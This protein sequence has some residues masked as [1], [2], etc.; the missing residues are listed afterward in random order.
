VHQAKSGSRATEVQQGLLVFQDQMV[1][2]VLLVSL[3]SLV[4]S[5]REEP[6]ALLDRKVTVGLPDSRVCRAIL[7]SHSAYFPLICIQ[8]WRLFLDVQQTHQHFNSGIRNVV[9]I[10]NDCAQLLHVLLT[11]YSLQWPAEWC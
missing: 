9:M 8:S 4:Q 11:V 3:V 7:V 10:R 5:D 1:H 2:R 6:L